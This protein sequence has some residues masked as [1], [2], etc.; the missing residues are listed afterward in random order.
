MKLSDTELFFFLE[1]GFLITISISLLGIGL[2][3]LSISSKFSLWMLYEE[4]TLSVSF[5]S[6]KSLCVLV[7]QSC[8]TLCDLMDCSLPGTSVRGIF[9]ARVL[10]WV[11]I[12]FSRRS[13]SPTDRTWLLNCRQ[14]LYCL[15]HQV[16]C[17]LVHSCL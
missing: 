17:L 4:N 7:A 13:S 3:R 9:Q 15:I 14:I 10:E 11:G 5:R 8:Q 1:G 16:V 2:S 12:S 6:F